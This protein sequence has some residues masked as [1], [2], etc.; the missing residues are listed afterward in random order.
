MYSDADVEGS[1]TEMGSWERNWVKK[2]AIRNRIGPRK[3]YAVTWPG[4]TPLVI[5]LG[6]ILY[7]IQWQNRQ[8]KNKN[9]STQNVWSYK[10]RDLLP[11][12]KTTVGPDKRVTEF[13]HSPT[14]MLIRTST[15]SP[16]RVVIKTT[17]TI[18]VH[19][20]NFRDQSQTTQNI[21]SFHIQI[22]YKPSDSIQRGR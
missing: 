2:S 14:S 15:T 12:L 22:N 19:G 20:V 8:W 5:R 11:P 3:F 10:A 1:E 13:S 4:F 9:S 16:R 21:L 7:P 6:P 18:L 17:I